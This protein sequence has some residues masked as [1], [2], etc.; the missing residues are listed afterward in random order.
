MDPPGNVLMTSYCLP[1][2]IYENAYSLI[3]VVLLD[4]SM[5]LYLNWVNWLFICWKQWG[6]ALF[7]NYFMD[8]HVIRRALFDLR[9]CSDFDTICSARCTTVLGQLFQ[10]HYNRFRLINSKEML[11]Q[12]IIFAYY[13]VINRLFTLEGKTNF[14]P[15]ETATFGC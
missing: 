15:P 2:Q 7:T 6:N 5:L 10:T 3:Q 8:S 11:P 4:V 1:K 13:R 12:C 14:L 9:C